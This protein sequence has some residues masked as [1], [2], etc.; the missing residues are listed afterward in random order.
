[1]PWGYF[2]DKNSKA[3]NAAGIEGEGKEEM[4]SQALTTFM[5]GSF[6]EMG[7]QGR[8]LRKMTGS[9]CILKAIPVLRIK[10]GERDRAE[11]GD[12]AI[13]QV[14]SDARMKMVAVEVLRSG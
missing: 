9:T 7:S 12:L 3:A 2:A 10:G 5:T 14:S 6:F 4:V 13:I 11:T 1:M 8:I